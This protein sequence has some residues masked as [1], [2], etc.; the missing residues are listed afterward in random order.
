MQEGIILIG[1]D[2]S[3][4][5]RGTG[6]ERGFVCIGHG[7]PNSAR[8]SG[9]PSWTS[10]ART[11]PIHETFPLRWSLR[12]Q[13]GLLLVSQCRALASWGVAAGAE[14]DVV[15]CGLGLLRREGTPLGRKAVAVPS[16]GQ[17]QTLLE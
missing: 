3:R 6:I 10:R 15:Q 9:M 4:F 1:S 17:T 12:L 5:S 13:L 2:S 16:F 11:P 7:S 8:R 14:S